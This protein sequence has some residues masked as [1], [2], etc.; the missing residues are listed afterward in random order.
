MRLNRRRLC[1]DV[2][3]VSVGVFE[4]LEFSEFLSR[5]NPPNAGEEEEHGHVPGVHADDE[6]ERCQMP[7]WDAGGPAQS[8]GLRV[9]DDPDVVRGVGGVDEHHVV[10]EDA[11]GQ[12]NTDQVNIR[13]PARGLGF[14]LLSLEAGAGDTGHVEDHAGG[15][16]CGVARHGP[17]DSL[18]TLVTSLEPITSSSENTL[19][20]EFPL[21]ENASTVL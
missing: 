3:S 18:Q 11:P 14:L 17:D 4:L 9:G 6:P 20:T 2:Y 16:V 8:A 12:H 15:Q 5:N 21:T 1:R 7:L 19:F 10:E 13:P